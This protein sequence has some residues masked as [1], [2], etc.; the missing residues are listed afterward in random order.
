MRVREGGKVAHTG[1]ISFMTEQRIRGVVGGE[2]KVSGGVF[3]VRRTYT[4]HLL[5][6]SSATGGNK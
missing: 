5:S 4:T 1:K 2:E 6:L 3:A